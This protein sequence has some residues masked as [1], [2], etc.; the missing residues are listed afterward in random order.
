MKK[1][2]SKNGS[3]KY[4]IKKKKVVE[5]ISYP[6]EKWFANKQTLLYKGV[7]YGIESR[8]LVQ[9]LRNQAFMLGLS[10]S[11]KAQTYAISI[12]VWNRVKRGKA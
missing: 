3:D 1:F 10:I 8:K 5:V 9:Q 4:G 12:T 6:F 7:D 11:C 2:G